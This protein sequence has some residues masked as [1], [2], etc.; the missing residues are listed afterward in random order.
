MDHSA[1]LTAIQNISTQGASDVKFF[2]PSGQSDVYLIVA[3]Q[4]NN[5]GQTHIS[6]QVLL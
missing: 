4:M 1:K 6:S 2:Q 3:N 5:A